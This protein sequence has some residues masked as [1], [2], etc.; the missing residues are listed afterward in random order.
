MKKLNKPFKAKPDTK[1]INSDISFFSVKGYI[2]AV[3]AA[4]LIS[5][6]PPLIFDFNISVFF[7]KYGFLWGGELENPIDYQHFEKDIE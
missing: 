6:I 7:T 5:L 3:L 1:E 2:I 4:L